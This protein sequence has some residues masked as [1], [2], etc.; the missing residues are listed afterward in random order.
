M[1]VHLKTQTLA[2]PKTYSI[3]VA[4]TAIRSFMV[5]TVEDNFTKYFTS[6]T[7]MLG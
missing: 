1:K 2:K 7:S 6:V 5:T 3:S 4:L